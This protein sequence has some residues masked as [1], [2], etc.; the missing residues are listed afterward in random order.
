MGSASRIVGLVRRVRL[1]GVAQVAGALLMAALVPVSLVACRSKPNGDAPV[2]ASAA[3]VEPPSVVD[4]VEGGASPEA[5]VEAGNRF[6]DAE[7]KV[8]VDADG[9]VDPA[10]SGPEIALA[11][12]VVDKRCAI[13]S[14][15]AK[16][17]RAILEQ[18]GGRALPLRQEAK[19]GADGR[20]T[21]RLVNTGAAPL[22]LPLSFSAKLPA[23]TLLAEDDHHTIYEVE[24]PRLDV[25]AASPEAAAANERPHFARIVLAPGAA[26][27][28]TVTL[29]GVVL[30]VVGHGPGAE[31]CPD[32]GACA[33]APA[34]LA[35][36]RNTM[37]LGELLTDVEVGAPARVSVEL[38]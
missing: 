13:G 15:R 32:G 36:G 6:R 31:K 16:Q 11:L 25:A 12:A 9:P 19:L 22:T 27:V 38:P 4:G 18:D 37:H 23:F 3:A 29:G 30:G 17:L 5:L 26:A 35:K 28:A 10:C 20:V 14:G 7:P 2:D 1:A 24:P 21:L 8:T 34:H 33:R